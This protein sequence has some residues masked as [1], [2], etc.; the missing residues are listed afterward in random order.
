ML[1]EAACVH[2]NQW[3]DGSACAAATCPADENSAS[4]RSPPRCVG[5][6]YMRTSLQDAMPRGAA[7]VGQCLGR[8][9]WRVRNLACTSSVL[10]S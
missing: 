6:E 2:A 8:E 3:R 7:C 5:R 4:D 10:G 1:K 9:H